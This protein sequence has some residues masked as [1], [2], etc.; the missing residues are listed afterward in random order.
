MWRYIDSDSIEKGPLA[1]AQK[2]G[3]SKLELEAR[4]MSIEARL[5]ELE[6]EVNYLR[7]LPKGA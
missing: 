3:K 7:L 4:I 5:N 1:L 2:E 6:S